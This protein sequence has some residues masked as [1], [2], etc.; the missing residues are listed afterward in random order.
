MWQIHTNILLDNAST[1]ARPPTKVSDRSRRNIEEVSSEDDLD[2]AVQG[3]DE[4]ADSAVL[5]SAAICRPC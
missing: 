4:Y 2:E 1:T 3:G 5:T